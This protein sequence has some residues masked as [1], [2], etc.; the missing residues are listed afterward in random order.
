MNVRDQRKLGYN[1]LPVLLIHMQ[2]WEHGSTVKPRLSS[3][4]NLIGRFAIFI[5]LELPDEQRGLQGSAGRECDKAAG[6]AGPGFTESR[7]Q[8]AGHLS[9]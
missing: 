5:L 4:Q 6:S 8:A 2:L 3:V 7:T 1:V 9:W